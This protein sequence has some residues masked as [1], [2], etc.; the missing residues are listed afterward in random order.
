MSDRCSFASAARPPMEESWRLGVGITAPMGAA[1]GPRRSAVRAARA[2]ASLS[3][4]RREPRA[5]VDPDTDVSP[6]RGAGERG[7]RVQA[8]VVELELE[9]DAVLERHRA[10]DARLERAGRVERDVRGP[11]QH[12]LVAV[13]EAPV[14]AEEARDHHA[15]AAARAARGADRTRPGGHRSGSAGGRRAPTPRPG[16]GR[17]PA[18]RACSSAAPTARPRAGWPGPRRRGRRT[19]RRASARRDGPRSRG[20]GGRGD[21]RHPTASPRGA[22]PG[23]RRRSRG[24]PRGRARPARIAARPTTR[25]RASRSRARVRRARSG[26]CSAIADP[27]VALDPTF[28]RGQRAGER[29]EQRALAGA[30]GS[31]QRD[32]L[33][34]AELD[35]DVGHDLALAAP[36][37]SGARS[38]AARLRRRAIVTLTS[39][40]GSAGGSR[41]PGAG[42]CR[43]RTSG[44]GS[45]RS[46][47]SRSR[48]RRRSSRR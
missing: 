11:R 9:A 47:R 4:R 25:A 29:V 42:A 45:A 48:R 15:R 27:A 8:A 43:G 16:R 22:A 34:G 44:S 46:A 35:A 30:V 41:C 6:G 12:Q 32:D 20:R 13:F 3:P 23:G 24:A 37:A 39:P 40:T 10:G 14:V 33:A 38:A 17:R 19:A 26:D 21:A 1:S 28:R 5:A 7:D 2:P 18:S 31:E 36:D